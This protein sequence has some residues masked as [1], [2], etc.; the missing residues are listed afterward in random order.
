MTT[1]QTTLQLMQDTT[2]AACTLPGLIEAIGTDTFEPHLISLLN[3]TCGAEHCAAFRFDKDALHEIVALSIDGSK[4]AQNQA[5]I[6]LN[7]QFWRGDPALAKALRLINQGIPSTSLVPISH[8]EDADLR[9][10]V[11]PQ[12]RERVLI[13][14]KGTGAAFVLSILRGKRGDTFSDMEMNWLGTAGETLV[15]AISKHYDVLSR[16][17]SLALASLPDI[18]ARIRATMSLP[19]R[20]GE[21]CARILY[22]LSSVGAAIDLGIGTESVKTYR[23]R[24]YQRLGI[25]SPRELLLWYLSMWDTP[26][27]HAPLTA[28]GP[29]YTKRVSSQV[30]YARHA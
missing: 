2:S 29:A 6:Y 21:V 14:G 17:S 12:V 16:K 9:F 27:K 11:Y 15:A 20:E 28:D 3:Q 1:K 26:H 18:E 30:A 8:L 4:A 7:R 24:A 25:G 22:G 5:S 19:Y 13:C 10:K 23:K